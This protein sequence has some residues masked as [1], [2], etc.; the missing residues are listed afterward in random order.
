MR[1]KPVSS[2]LVR[3]IVI[4]LVLVLMLIIAD[5]PF[6]ICVT[7]HMQIRAL[8]Y[9]YYMFPF[10]Y[11]CTTPFLPLV[12]THKESCISGSFLICISTYIS[13][14]CVST[15]IQEPFLIRINTHI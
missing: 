3:V 1:E 11:V 7:V 10:L 8:S 14:V 6:S 2:V 5:V 12:H 15:H 4:L 13:Y 9:M